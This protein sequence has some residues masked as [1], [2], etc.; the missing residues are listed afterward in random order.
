MSFSFGRLWLSGFGVIAVADAGERSERLRPYQRPCTDTDWRFAF[1]TCSDDGYRTI[2]AHPAGIASLNGKVH[3]VCDPTVAGARQVPDPLFNVPCSYACG[4]GTQLSADLAYRGDT[5]GSTQPAAMVP[6]CEVCPSGKYSLGGGTIISGVAGDWYKEWP[7]ALQSS[8]FYKSEDGNWLVGKAHRQRCELRIEAPAGLA[9]AYA[10]KMAPWNAPAPLV[11]DL[12]GLPDDDTSCKPLKKKMF[13]GKIVLAWDHPGCS[14]VQQA[15]RASRARAM[16]V[17]LVSSLNWAF[18]PN[19]PAWASRLPERLRVPVLVVS[20]ADGEIFGFA[21]ANK[22][23]PVRVNVTSPACFLGSSLAATTDPNAQ[24]PLGQGCEAWAADPSGR[25]VQSGDNSRFSEMLSLLTLTVHLVRDGHVLFRYTVDSERGFDG[26]TFKVDW[27][28]VMPLES[29]QHDYK[30]FR[31]ELPAGPHTMRWEFTKDYMGG[32]GEDKARIQLVEVVGTSF[33]DLVCRSCHNARMHSGVGAVHCNACGRDK[34]LTA[35]G[36]TAQN[37][38]QCSACPSGR[39]APPGSVGNASCLLQE[40]CQTKD[41]EVYYMPCQGNR[42]VKRFRW[43]DPVICKPGDPVSVSLNATQTSTDCVP[44]QPHEWRPDGGQCVA[45]IRQCEPGLR[46]VRERKVSFWHEWPRNISH[47]VYIVR[48]HD[49]WDERDPSADILGGDHPYGYR[50]RLGTAGSFAYAGDESMDCTLRGPV[51]RHCTSSQLKVSSRSEEYG[52]ALLHLEVLTDAPGEVR[53]VVE[54]TPADA[55]GKEARF[56]H[57]GAVPSALRIERK[58]QF[59]IHGSR[60]LGSMPITAGM[61]RLTWVWSYG[62]GDEIDVDVK[63]NRPVRGIRLLNVTVVHAVGAGTSQ[64]EPCQ[65]GQKVSKDGT[66]CFACPPGSVL[67]PGTMSMDTAR[68]S[69]TA[70]I[71]HCHPCA[72]GSFSAAGSTVCS[73]CGEGTRS[74]S[75]GS[76]CET[77]DVLIAKDSLGQFGGGASE[78]TFNMREI[79]SAWQTVAGRPAGPFAIAGHQYFLEFFEKSQMPG[80]VHGD[81]AYVWELPSLE[82]LSTPVSFAQQGQAQCSGAG[83]PG[84]AASLGD[85]IKTARAVV[86]GG[87]RGVQLAFGNGD[88][89]PGEPAGGKRRNASIFFQCDPNAPEA[90]AR[91]DHFGIRHLPRLRLA[92][93]AAMPAR[94]TCNDLR[95]EYAT[96]SACPRCRK[97]DYLPQAGLCKGNGFR[98]ITYIVGP[99]CVAGVQ[100]P[101][102]TTELCEIPAESKQTAKTVIQVLIVLAVFIGTCLCFYA[103]LLH[104]RYRKLAQA[105]N[106]RTSSAAV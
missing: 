43:R 46:A 63:H 7:S 68:P 105:G 25:F 93:G 38:E 48:Q 66:S 84:D 37:F 74:S 27:R 30:E 90:V 57:Y 92:R 77:M 53:F 21:A 100:Q 87:L 54:V 96:L 104:K 59:G 72:A 39:W 49:L 19:S 1:G 12:V 89:C 45:R 99:P 106:L 83:M 60:I 56:Q 73:L 101:E 97:E 6:R 10:A 55:W 88:L 62:Q 28:T 31:A 65:P 82:S 103:C 50:W 33:A 17:I 64:C 5:P 79:A 76:R 20:R 3:P 8:C 36:Q 78:L 61:H 11:G 51:R 4:A 81:L 18:R 94:G 58:G 9:G 95:L 52:D 26:L 40:A 42:R 32:M 69:T 67:L 2:F 35:G 41:T 98:D 23:R 15:K 70:K 71:S 47:E 75:D 29:E 80:D 102:G 22:A 91:V 44:C 86:I 14:P 13:A 34:Y 85:S 24:E 16:G